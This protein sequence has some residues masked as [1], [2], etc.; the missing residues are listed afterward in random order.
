MNDLSVNDE[1]DEMPGDT[2]ND[3]LLDE[4]GEAV[5]SAVGSPTNNRQLLA[6]L[7]VAE[8]RS[9]C[10][11]GRARAWSQLPYQP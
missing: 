5:P 6:T 2:I 7:A 8:V 4:P 11:Q 9:N 10:R 3:P 1:F